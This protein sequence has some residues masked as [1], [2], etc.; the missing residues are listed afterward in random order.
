MRLG[1]SRCR[2]RWRGQWV[3]RWSIIGRWWRG[4]STGIGPG[5]R[6]VI[7]WASSVPG[8]R[9]GSVTASPSTGP[10]TGCWP[11]CS[12]RRRPGAKST[13]GSASTRRSPGSISTVRPHRCRVGQPVS[14]TVGARSNDKKPGV[15]LDEP[16]DHAIGRSRGGLTTRAHTLVDCLGGPLVIAVTPRHA[17]TPRRCPGCSPSGGCPDRGPAGR[18]PDPRRC[19][20]TRRTPPADTARTCA[21]GGSPRSSPNPGTR[22][23]TGPGEGPAAVARSPSTPTTARAAT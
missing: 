12:P 17:G 22:S 13:G 7:C 2:R 6:G 4:R 15:R 23:A 11:R 10:R 9:S 8:R 3:G 19:A 14:H 16:G 21:L 18:A 5:S 20:G 1:S